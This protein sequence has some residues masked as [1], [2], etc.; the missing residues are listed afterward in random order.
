M[1]SYYPKKDELPG[2]YRTRLQEMEKLDKT[3]HFNPRLEDK[4]SITT[5]SSLQISA[6][7]QKNILS[8]SQSLPIE[9][10]ASIYKGEMASY[11]ENDLV[12]RK[13]DHIHH[14]YTK[15]NT[16]MR[17]KRTSYQESPN[18]LKNIILQ[19]NLKNASA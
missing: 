15:E 7:V 16:S 5:K 6:E 8:Y 9:I 10:G 18:F 4:E 12:W 2:D 1:T 14:G 17:Y 13:L 19:T 11:K 3:W